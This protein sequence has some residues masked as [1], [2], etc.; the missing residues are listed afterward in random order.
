MLKSFSRCTSHSDR[1]HF[2]Q[3][4]FL[5][6]MVFGAIA[7]TDVS[8]G[9][10]RADG[11]TTMERRRQGDIR[12]RALRLAAICS[13]ETFRRRVVL[14]F[15][16]LV[17]AVGSSLVL[18]PAARA[19]SPEIAIP[20]SSASPPASA[21]GTSEP[22][23]IS[24]SWDTNGQLESKTVGTGAAAHTT[25]YSF[26]GRHALLGATL[27]DGTNV[28]YRYQAD[29][30]LQS[31]TKTSPD[32]ATN[33]V[34]FIINT[35]RRYPQVVAEY[36][37][38]GHALAT[39]T[40]G[41][42]DELLLRTRAGEETYYHHDGNGSVVALTDTSG[43]VTQTYGY[44]AWG[45]EVEQSG[46]HDDNP[47]RYAGERYD[48]DLG[49]IYLRARWYDPFVGRFVS[50]DE[51][52]GRATKPVT[53]NTYV[54]ANADP[55][56]SRD[57]SGMETLDGLETAEIGE[58]TLT[59]SANGEI[60]ATVSGQAAN[61][62]GRVAEQ[63]VENAIKNCLKPGVIFKRLARGDTIRTIS[64][65]KAVPDF[66]FKV[67]EKITYLEVKTKLPLKSAGEAFA[68]AAKQLQAAID[69]NRRIFGLSFN[70]LGDVA[71]SNR[72]GLLLKE[73]SGDAN[74]VTLVNGFINLS[75]FLTDFV[76]ENCL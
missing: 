38:A 61:A 75:Q 6:T 5:T 35:N 11:S 64:K 22:L 7:R 10:T 43:Q 55:V 66:L 44:D 37:D 14:S 57:P 3:E 39:Y 21:A 72:E 24:Y 27:P 17:A 70:Q 16:L 34:H 63:V 68:R 56:G 54:Y 1:A 28:A 8:S 41:A 13:A 67:G 48:A 49:F 53:L 62:A 74:L 32:G 30:N 36:D 19:R 59:V 25:R 4:A 76:R 42:N 71:F 51:L 69:N 9:Q 60:G 40:Y 47:Y 2:L 12:Q 58:S 20:D 26:D 29:G 65:L 23:Q 52:P 45:N 18:A 15:A 31:R 33:T 73:L 50:P 46:G